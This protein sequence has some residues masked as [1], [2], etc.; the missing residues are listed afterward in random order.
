MSS[1][2][3]A[4]LKAAAA[5]CASQ[6]VG[7]SPDDAASGL[8]AADELRALF[9]PLVRTRGGGNAAAS[10]V[11]P[12]AARQAAAADQAPL[13]LLQLPGDLLVLVF[14]RLDACSL[15]RVAASC[16]ELY[17]SKPCPMTPVEE[18]LR[19][20]AAA[21]GRVCPARLPHEFSSWAVHLAWLEHRRDEAWAPV[22]P[23]FSSSLFV[24]EDG[25]PM[26]CG[27]EYE[28]APRV[29]GLGEL[30]GEDCAVPTP[31]LLLSMDGVRVSSVA[32]GIMFTA[33]VSAACTV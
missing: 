22:G 1:I 5:A 24:A 23:S 3:L 13:T 28:A 29:L 33:A 25:R 30:E 4:S 14:W 15:A 7:F 10:G 31:T 11:P 9:L 12:P 8:L 19:K 18:V 2:A 32:A 17:H 27:V 21:R 26:S 16:S 20:R 6:A